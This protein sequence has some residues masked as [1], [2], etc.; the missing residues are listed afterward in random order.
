MNVTGRRGHDEPGAMSAEDLSANVGFM[1]KLARLYNSRRRSL[2]LQQ[3]AMNVSCLLY[4]LLMVTLN[5]ASD[6]RANGLGLGLG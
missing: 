2:I 6:Y 5:N 4:S 1:V 3:S